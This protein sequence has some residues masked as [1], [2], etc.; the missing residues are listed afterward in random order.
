MFV[1]DIIHDRH[2]YAN[3]TQ[4]NDLINCICLTEIYSNDF[5]VIFN[6]QN[7]LHIIS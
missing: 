5:V 2:V 6:I 1:I 4:S 3:E 7:H